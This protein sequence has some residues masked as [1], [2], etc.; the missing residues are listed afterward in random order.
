MT[1]SLVCECAAALKITFVSALTDLE[2]LA[3]SSSSTITLDV[4]LKNSVKQ[5]AGEWCECT[6]GFTDPK[7]IV[8]VH[9]RHCQV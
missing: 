3:F 9:S 7:C 5:N 4:I 8:E 6:D 1:V 2:V